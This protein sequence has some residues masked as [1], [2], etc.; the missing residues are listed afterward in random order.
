MFINIFPCC[1]AYLIL[2][3]LI[4]SSHDKIN[5]DDTPMHASVSIAYLFKVK[6]DKNA[7]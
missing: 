2:V 1:Y 4:M 6:L 5:G 3:S 7:E